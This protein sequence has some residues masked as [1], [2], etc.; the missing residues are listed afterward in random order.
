VSRYD[1]VLLDAF[2]TLIALDRP[3]SRLR[4]SLRT[5]LGLELDEDRARTAVRAEVAHYA[6]NCRT[7]V[8]EAALAA[9]RW[10]CAGV[11][12]RELDL[13][14]DRDLLLEVLSDSVV[15]RPFADAAPAMRTLARRGVAMAVVSNG[16]CSLAASLEA[17]GLRAE[18]VVDSATGGATKPD[19]AIFRRALAL[20]GVEAAR[21][22]HVGD[23]PEADV[24]GA[25]AAGIDA[26]LLDRWGSQAAGTIA[27]LAELEALVG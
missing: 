8:D 11:I 1:A 2:G 27:S 25:R 16:D 24:A 4:S 5:R 15:L 17:A 26:V 12:G 20:L 18:I 14:A 13:D 19:P 23:D 6:A 7:A 22:L 10:E 21:T 3:V 9:L